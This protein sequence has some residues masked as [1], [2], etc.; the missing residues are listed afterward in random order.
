MGT[1]HNEFQSLTKIKN[2]TLL[3][4]LANEY[5]SQDLFLEKMGTEITENIAVL[6]KDITSLKKEYPGKFVTEINTEDIIKKLERDGASLLSHDEKI[7]N[8]CESGKLGSALESHVKEIKEAIYKIWLQV[9][10]SDAGYRKKDSFGG[11]FGQFDIFSGLGKLVSVVGKFIAGVLV[12]AIAGCLYLY[13]T[14]E[15]ESTLRKENEESMSFIG[16][17]IARI[18]KIEQK[19]VDLNES[20]STHD[21]KELTQGAKIAILDLEVTIQEMNQEIHKIEGKIESQKNAVSKNN[22]KLGKIK[23]KPFIDRLL[24]R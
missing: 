17:Q 23:G 16:E 19:K 8:D 12:I 5:I 2:N 15:K 1:V 22:K 7:V 6:R 20:L 3:L 10:G 21:D 13:I 18:K 9:H 11:F 4:V 24:R 14:M